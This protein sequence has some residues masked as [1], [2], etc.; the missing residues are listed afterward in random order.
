MPKRVDGTESGWAQGPAWRVANPYQ[1]WWGCWLPRHPA[2]RTSPNDQ[3]SGKAD[4]GT[5]TPSG[6]AR[7]EHP[8]LVQSLSME[9]ERSFRVDPK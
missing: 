9:R 4:P 2:T 1:P 3:W 6:D 8:H 7:P 5:F